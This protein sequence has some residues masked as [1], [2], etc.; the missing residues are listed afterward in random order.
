VLPRVVMGKSVECYRELLWASVDRREKPSGEGMPY[1]NKGL[2]M[3][4]Y[5]QVC[6]T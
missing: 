3:K 5:P 2:R 4:Q 1:Q 6:P